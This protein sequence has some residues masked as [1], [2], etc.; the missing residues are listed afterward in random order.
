VSRFK[1]IPL[2]LKET[3]CLHA[4]ATYAVLVDAVTQFFHGQQPDLSWIN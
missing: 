4:R 3:C 2:S 1:W